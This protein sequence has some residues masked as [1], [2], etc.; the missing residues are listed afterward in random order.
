MHG[1]KTNM[2]RLFVSTKS[3]AVFDQLNFLQGWF[4]SWD[5]LNRQIQTSNQ[6]VTSFILCHIKSSISLYE[7]VYK[8]EKM[9]GVVSI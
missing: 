5:L 8:L 7:R 6:I 2:I 1:S 3:L 4:T 9:V